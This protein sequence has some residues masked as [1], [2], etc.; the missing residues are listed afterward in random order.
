MLAST[1]V[2]LIN[3]KAVIPSN[4]IHKYMENPLVKLFYLIMNTHK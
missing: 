1:L 2:K 4:A 3:F